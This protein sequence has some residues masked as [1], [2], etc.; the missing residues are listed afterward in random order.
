MNYAEARDQ[1]RRLVILRLLEESDGSANEG[2]LRTGLDMLG[3][4]VKLTRQVVRADLDLLEKAGCVR[5]EWFDDKIV[6]A[7]LTERGVDCVHGRVEVH[8]VKKPGIGG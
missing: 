4:G 8:G 5:L 6:V 2:M 3:H 7:H 1:D